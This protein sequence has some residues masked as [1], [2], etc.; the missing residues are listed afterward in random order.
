MS[1]AGFSTINLSL[2]TYV[3]SN[4]RKYQMLIDHYSIAIWDRHRFITVLIIVLSL[5]QWAVILQGIL[6]IL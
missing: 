6:I 3:L 5:G 4:V 1:S 2:R